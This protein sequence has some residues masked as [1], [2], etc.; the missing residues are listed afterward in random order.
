MNPR[1][2]TH[3]SKFLRVQSVFLNSLT[4]SPTDRLNGLVAPDTVLSYEA[5]RQIVHH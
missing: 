5:L 1:P 4:K 3:S 2:K